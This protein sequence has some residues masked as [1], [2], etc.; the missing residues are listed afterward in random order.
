MNNSI[1]IYN[2]SQILTMDSESLNDVGLIENGYILVEDGKIVEIDHMSCIDKNLLEN[3]KYQKVDAKHRVVLPGFV[4][5]HTHA[6]F[7]GS[8]VKE[9]AI[10]LTD[11]SPDALKKLGTETGM[12]GTIEKTRKL[13]VEE[14]EN[15]SFKRIHSMLLNGTTTIEIKTGYGLTTESEIKMLEVNKRLNDKLP[16]DIFTTF[17][18]AHYWPKDMAKEKYIDLL[19]KEMIPE[20]SKLKLAQ[21]CDIWCDDGYYS[22][23]ECE[24][25]LSCGRSYGMIP[26]IHTDAYSYIEGTDLAVDMGMVSADHLNYTPASVF[27]KMAKG[28]VVGVVL[29]CTDFAVKHPQPFNPRPMLDANMTVAIASNINPGVWVGSMQFVLI[30]ATKLHGFSPEEALIATTRSGAKALGLHDRGVLKRGFKADIQM[31]DLETYEDIVYKFDIE[32]IDKVIKDG[33]IVVDNGIIK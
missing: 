11:N 15:Q 20:I 24:K 17:L 22:K 29:P 3:V 9:Y 28:N 12:Y 10:K 6:V 25:V 14:L 31:W 4:D 16:M 13:S 2:A 8:R 26:K 5:C 30:L 33:K 18:G 1:L 7:G 21:F 27:K 23:S 32:Y 19:T